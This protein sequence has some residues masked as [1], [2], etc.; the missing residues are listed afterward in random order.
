MTGKQ[1]SDLTFFI[2]LAF[3][4]LTLWRNLGDRDIRDARITNHQRFLIPAI[5]GIVLGD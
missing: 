2:L 3:P 4:G 5:R 1:R